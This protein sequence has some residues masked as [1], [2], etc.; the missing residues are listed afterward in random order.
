MIIDEAIKELE[1]LSIPIKTRADYRK[2]LAVRLGIEA[3]WRVKQRRQ[4][5]CDLEDQFL[6]GETEK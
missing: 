4:N 2:H 5:V 6:P 1:E 3:L